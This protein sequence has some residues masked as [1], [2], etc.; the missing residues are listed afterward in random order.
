MKECPTPI[1]ASTRENEK[2]TARPAKCP[3]R[4]PVKLIRG[5]PLMLHEGKRRGL[6]AV[7]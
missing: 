4:H 7:R 6:V 5:L 2:G 3:D 1:L